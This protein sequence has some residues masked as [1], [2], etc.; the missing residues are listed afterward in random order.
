MK[1]YAAE[2]KLGLGKLIQENATLRIT[3][4][5]KPNPENKDKDLPKCQNLKASLLEWSD[6]FPF[7]SILGSTTVNL[8]DV[9]FT[10]ED[11]WAAR[12][13]AVDKP[14]NINHNQFD[15]VG[16]ITAGKP[17]DDELNEIPEDT[18][19]EDLPDKFHILID[20]VI[21]KHWADKE[22]Q[23][24]INEILGEI[25]SDEWCVSMEL[26]Q[27]EFDYAIEKEPSV[28][29]V[30]ART[31]DTAFLTQ[32]LRLFKGSGE[33][34]GKKLCIVPRNFIF[35][36][37]GLTK[38]PANPE[39]VITSYG[40]FQEPVQITAGVISMDELQKLQAK[41]DELVAKHEALVA[42]QSKAVVDKLEAD[43]SAVKAD[44]KTK[45]GENKTLSAKVTELEASVAD[46]NAKL[47]ASET[48]K[49][50]LTA[51]NATLTEKVAAFE[52]ESI[53]ASRYAD[54]IAANVDAD[55][56]KA[57]APIYAKL[58]DDDFKGVL[59]SLTVAKVEPTV[60]K[61]EAAKTVIENAK[62]TEE[63]KIPA[64]ETGSEIKA[65]YA[66]CADFYTTAES[67][68]RKNPRGR[69]TK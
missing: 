52:A 45:E 56:A 54:L 68:D 27:N 44:V 62:V 16:H 4:K 24:E 2:E 57:L 60:T 6:L 8:N 50:T 12:H 51:S 39:S 55:R 66:A 38:N 64:P 61:V 67:V 29:Q 47:T 42:S 13:T 46:L 21:Y 14:L 5:L 15:I 58:S 17:V 26:L 23:K 63:T 65:V 1:I 34:E 48:E 49:S 31:E 20:S 3:A 7:E 22:K 35:S 69:K 41:F 40:S 11:V 30:V 59:P 19:V 18:A 53:K 10:K 36:G 25:V 33:Y 37:V 43:F 9:L 28:Y 32:H